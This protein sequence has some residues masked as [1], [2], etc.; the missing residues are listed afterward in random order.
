MVLQLDQLFIYLVKRLVV[1]T[2][3]LIVVH[4]ERKLIQS[5]LWK[6]HLHFPLSFSKSDMYS[7]ILF[8]FFFKEKAFVSSI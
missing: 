7:I 3:G 5:I 2:T 4:T 6:L 8:L 1:D